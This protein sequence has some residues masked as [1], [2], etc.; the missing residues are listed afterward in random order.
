MTKKA[1]GPGGVQ[2]AGNGD[3][4]T[5]RV[6]FSG[7]CAFVP[8]VDS[9]HSLK[10]MDVILVADDDKEAYAEIHRPVVGIYVKNLRGAADNG[11]LGDTMAFFELDREDVE[12][13]RLERG[14]ATAEA[15]K[16]VGSI[17]YLGNGKLGSKP[18]LSA[19]I[20]DST[21]IAQDFKQQQ[22]D[23]CW[24]PRMKRI[25][26]EASRIDSRLVVDSI[27]ANIVKAR[28]LVS[29]GDF[30]SHQLGRYNAGFV[31]AQFT[32]AIKANAPVRQA[33]AHWAGSDTPVDSKYDI[34]VRISKMGKPENKRE[35]V[36][37]ARDESTL[38]VRISNLCC[39]YYGSEDVNGL[40]ILRNLEPDDD[41]QR[42]YDLLPDQGAAMRQKYSRLPQPIPVDYPALPE[43]ETG[44]VD[45]VRC[46]G[47]RFKPVDFTA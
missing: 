46:S 40:K 4:Y 36:L 30:G 43:S 5:F 26:P 24:V 44:G 32:P 31:V 14:K 11:D 23:F 10:R 47:V 27:P 25:L 33:I 16:L 8:R 21:Q 42:F 38:E 2:P 13:F 1:N 28:A 12:F 17:G 9:A 19:T 41:F 7:L 3:S 6:S 45:P 29:S 35:V 20:T 15:E 39:G 34:L 37:R 22:A 18:L